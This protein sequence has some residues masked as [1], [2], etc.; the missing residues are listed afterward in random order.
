[1]GYKHIASD[2]SE[3]VV[4]GITNEYYLMNQNTKII[5]VDDYPLFREGMKLLIEM[6]GIGQVIAEADNGQ[7]FLDLLRTLN[8]D[9]VLMDIEMPV[10]GGLE[11][12]MKAIAFRPGLKVLAITMYSDKFNYMDLINSGFKGFVLKTAGKKEIEKAINT[13]ISGNSYFTE[14]HSS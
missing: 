10:M 11:A 5:I 3:T 1:M 6:E 7:E 8:P 14:K 2:N 9:L 12:T 4:F 13:I